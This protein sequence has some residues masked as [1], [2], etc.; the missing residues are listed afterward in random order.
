MTNFE[1]DFGRPREGP[2]PRGT[3]QNPVGCKNGGSVAGLARPVV[4]V[5]DIFEPSGDLKHAVL[6]ALGSG[7]R[8]YI[9]LLRTPA[10]TSPPTVFAV[11][12]KV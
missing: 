8:I 2:G 6:T 1:D 11:G 12:E 10:A 9:S 3:P 7:R 5:F 4:L